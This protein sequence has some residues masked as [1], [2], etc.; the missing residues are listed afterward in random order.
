MEYYYLHGGIHKGGIWEE[1]LSVEVIC[2]N[3]CGNLG[4]PLVSVVEQLLLVVQQLLVSLG[5]G[6]TQ[7]LIYEASEYKNL[8]FVAERMY[9]NLRRS[10]FF[11]LI[12][13][14]VIYTFVVL[15]GDEGLV[16]TSL[17]T[18]LNIYTYTYTN[19]VQRLLQCF[20]NHLNLWRYS[21][22]RKWF[23]F[24]KKILL[25]KHFLICRTDR[26]IT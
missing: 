22:L 21:K 15:G 12:K 3:V 18:P 25:L 1:E 24:S 9:R 14:S 6:A 7:N 26:I 23:L 5:T 13:R 2:L 19:T 8:V 10:F 16:P 4:L 20:F 17:N 11:P